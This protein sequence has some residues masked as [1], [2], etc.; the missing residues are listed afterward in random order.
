MQVAGLD[1]NWGILPWS[2]ASNPTCSWPPQCSIVLLIASAR[3][4][5]SSFHSLSLGN[6]QELYSVS[7]TDKLSILFFFLDPFLWSYSP[8]PSLRLRHAR[9]PVAAVCL[10]LPVHPFWPPGPLQAVVS[11]MEASSYCA[12]PFC[13]GIWGVEKKANKKKKTDGLCPPWRIRA[14]LRK[15]Q[16]K[17]KKLAFFWDSFEKKSHSDKLR[18]GAQS[19]A[20]LQLHWSYAYRRRSFFFFKWVLIFHVV[21]LRM[22][23]L[24]W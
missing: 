11:L 24:T 3:L 7:R 9:D 8:N 19:E 20:L 17:T 15:K 22:F 12:S 1:S 4:K 2:T 10:L 5:G 13:K 16:N 6:I 14:I 23:K 21:V 18:T